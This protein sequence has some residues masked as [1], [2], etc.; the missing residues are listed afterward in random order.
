MKKGV[1]LADEAPR[2][3]PLGPCPSMGLW[4]KPTINRIAPW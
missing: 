1:R 3:Q 4:L 2:A